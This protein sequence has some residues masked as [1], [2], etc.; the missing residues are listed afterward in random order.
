M[1][2]LQG[3]QLEKSA[4]YNA[5]LLSVMSVVNAKLLCVMSVLIQSSLWLACKH[6]GSSFVDT[7]SCCY[8]RLCL[9]AISSKHSNISIILYAGIRTESTSSYSKVSSVRQASKL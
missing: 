7:L 6:G 4:V 9:G 1:C 8:S 3:E 5:K 2:L